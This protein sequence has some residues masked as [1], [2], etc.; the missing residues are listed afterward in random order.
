LLSLARDFRVPRHDPFFISNPFA[1]AQ[2]STE[3]VWSC[4][5]T[6]LARPRTHFCDVEIAY[7]LCKSLIPHGR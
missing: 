7:S 5:T 6:A 1:F 3:A 2:N 4:Q